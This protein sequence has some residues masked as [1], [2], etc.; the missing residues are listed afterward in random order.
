MSTTELDDIVQAVWVR[1]LEYG[2]LEKY[3][4]ERGSFPAYLNVAVHNASW[5]LRRARL[6]RSK[7]MVMRGTEDSPDDPRSLFEEILC[8][9]DG[10]GSVRVQVN[11]ELTIIDNK[12]AVY[13]SE[14]ERASLYRQVGSGTPLIDILM[15]SGLDGSDIEDILES[16][17]L[18]R[19]TREAESQHSSHL[20]YSVCCRILGM[21]KISSLKVAATQS[22]EL[23]RKIYASLPLNYR[24]ARLFMVLSADG[25]TSFC[26]GVFGLFLLQ[27]VAGLPPVDPTS[28]LGRALTKG[29]KNLS[30]YMGSYAQAEISHFKNGVL[31]IL[32]IR[33]R[34]PAILLDILG[35]SF[36]NLLHNNAWKRIDPEQGLKAAKNY[37]FKIINNAAINRYKR[38]RR[39]DS[40]DSLTVMDDESG[41]VVEEE[42]PDFDSADIGGMI[43][44]RRMNDLLEDPEV[45]EDL[46]AVHPDALLFVKLLLDGETQK[47][48]LGDRKS[49]V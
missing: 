46:E 39:D 40:A 48:I 44:L 45:H 41:A 42:I 20:S 6:K 24:M 38:N 2:T 10:E 16:S 31:K 47:D 17:L 13:F 28:S 37:V 9:D 18:R 12:L 22:R 5:N 14:R 36:E 1:M 23:Q 43:D 15:G 35:D 21:D 49:V 8:T 32:G 29:D 27:G 7:E 19:V 30:R 11:A 34:N 3:T 25:V 4:K 26:Q 33:A